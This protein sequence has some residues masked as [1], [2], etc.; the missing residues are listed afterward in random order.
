MI[1]KIKSKPVDCKSYVKK[2]LKP[3]DST[4]ECMHA[5]NMDE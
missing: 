3:S 5:G 4:V 1:L 2:S